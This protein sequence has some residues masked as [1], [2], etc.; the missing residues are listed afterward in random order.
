MDRKL[1]QPGDVLHISGFI[2]EQ[3]EGGRWPWQAGQA[4][5][6]D[7]GIVDG[8]TGCLPPMHTLA[9]MPR[10]SDA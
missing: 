10:I 1:V 9:H 6:P 4:V 7:P 3:V 5:P 8:Q 2:Q